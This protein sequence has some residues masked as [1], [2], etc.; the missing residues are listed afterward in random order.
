MNIQIHKLEL[1]ERVNAH[2]QA[3]HAHDAGEQLLADSPFKGLDLD[4]ER[5]RDY[6]RD[7]PR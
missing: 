7:V 3:G 5:D 2:L 6:G 4:F 1:V